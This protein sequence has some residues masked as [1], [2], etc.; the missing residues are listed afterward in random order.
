[1]GFKDT[2][3]LSNDDANLAKKTF[4]KQ[5]LRHFSLE[6]RHKFIFLKLDIGKNRYFD[7]EV[8][9]LSRNDENKRI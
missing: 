3:V 7:R 8:L 1:M 2:V 6:N 9:L 5:T 4:T